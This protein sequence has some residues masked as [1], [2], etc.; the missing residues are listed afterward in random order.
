MVHNTEHSIQIDWSLLGSLFRCSSSSSATRCMTVANAMRLLHMF[1]ML[2]PSAEHA[3][4]EVIRGRA[5]MRHAKSQLCTAI[6]PHSGEAA[7]VDL[8]LKLPPLLLLFLGCMW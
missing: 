3:I 8:I 1:F 5:E 2:L 4:K 6:T 7:V